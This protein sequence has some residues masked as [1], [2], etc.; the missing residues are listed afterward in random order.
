[1]SKNDNFNNLVLRIYK[2]LNNK[3]ANIDD[4]LLTKI[5]KYLFIYND[6]YKKN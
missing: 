1:M 3:P 5:K 6:I 2:I 4:T